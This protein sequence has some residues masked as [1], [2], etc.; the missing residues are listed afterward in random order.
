MFDV[1]AGRDFYGPGGA[2]EVLAGRDASL[3]LAA[4]ETDP[5]KW[6][7]KSTY[8][9]LTGMESDTLND[10]LQRFED[11]YT[12]VGF[13]PEGFDGRSLAEMTEAAEAEAQAEA[14]AEAAALTAAA[15][16]DE[17]E[18]DS[19][20]QRGADGRSYADAAAAAVEGVGEGDKDKAE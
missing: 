15:D 2:Y 13:L 18:S 4:M 17:G 11:K 1:T 6:P 19:L 20:R 14:E 10:W 7:S 9:E 5:S 16:S 3:G 12:L 8:E